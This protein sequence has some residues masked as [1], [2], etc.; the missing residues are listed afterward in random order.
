MNTEFS[1][2]QICIRRYR[3][4]DAPFLY[5]AVRESI[6]EVSRWMAWCNRTYSLAET[7]AFLKTRDA[8]WDKGEHYSFA[9][10]DPH[11]HLFLGGVGLNF[12]NR[13]HKFA[14]LGYWVRTTQTRRGVASAA[15]RL[16]AR[17]GIERLGLNRIEIVA[18]VENVASQRVAEKAG[19]R[20]EGVLR[21]RVLVHEQPQDAVMY[22]LVA[23]DLK[24]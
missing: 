12:F 10:V 3:L 15:T 2:D 13:L 24:N 16:A 20:R 19:A 14:N 5:G 17:F 6:E 18:A 7:E 4:A 22:S 9:V 21:K 11:S 8:E 23:E 1:D